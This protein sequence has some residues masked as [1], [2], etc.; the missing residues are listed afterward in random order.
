MPVSP[1]TTTASTGMLKI[2]REIMR[3]ARKDLV[4][5]STS[6][7]L[8]LGDQQVLYDHKQVRVGVASPPVSLS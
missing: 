6:V 3:I 1:Q 4:P 2:R 7:G 5:T 8:C